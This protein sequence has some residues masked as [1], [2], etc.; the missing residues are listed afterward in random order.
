MAAA[1][2]PAASPPARVLYRDDFSNP[3]SGW[4]R[5][6]NDPATF[7]AGYE[8]EAYV[9]VRTAETPGRALVWRREGFTD[10]QAEIDARL[11]GPTEGRYVALILRRQENGEITPS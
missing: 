11:V 8:A 5:Q 1:P 4:L 9:L 6:S 7:L 2:A 3:N 10:F